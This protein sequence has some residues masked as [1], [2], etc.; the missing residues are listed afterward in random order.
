MPSLFEIVKLAEIAIIFYYMRAIKKSFIL[1]IVAKSP[2][3]LKKPK[4][5]ENRQK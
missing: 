2:F 1:K 3:C 5:V 4:K